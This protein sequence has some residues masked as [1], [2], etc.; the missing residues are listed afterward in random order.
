M[1]YELPKLHKRTIFV[2][3]KAK[4]M[5]LKKDRTMKFSNLKKTIMGALASLVAVSMI[6]SSCSSSKN[7]AGTSALEGEWNIVTACGKSAEGGMEPAFINFAKDGKVNGNAS[8]NSFFGSYTFD[9][10]KLKL[11]QVGMTR[12]MGPSMDIE[13]AVTKAINTVETIKIDGK[14]ATLFDAD[15]KEVMTIEKK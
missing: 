5:F 9:G 11:G 3:A 12:M 7:A 1:P 2:P 6:L 13:D 8:V 15:G 10:K 14:K 4:V